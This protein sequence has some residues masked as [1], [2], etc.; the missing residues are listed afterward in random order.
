MIHHNRHLYQSVQDK[1]V[2][3]LPVSLGGFGTDNLK[4]AADVL[5]ALRYRDLNRPGGAAVLGENGEFPT[6]LLP[7]GYLP[8][9]FVALYGPATINKL[10]TATFKITNYDKDTAYNITAVNGKA[11]QYGDL[12]AFA[13]GTATGAASLTINGTTYVV[14]VTSSSPNKPSIISPLMDS[15]NNESSITFLSNTF[16][17]PSY[18][19]VHASSD[20]QLSTDADFVNIVQESLGSTTNTTSWTVSGLSPSTQYFAR[21]RHTSL[22]T[23]SSQWSNSLRLMTRAFVPM[24]AT[25]ITSPSAGALNVDTR[26]TVT[27][28][29]YQNLGGVDI[30]LSTDWEIATDVLFNNLAWS[31]LNNTTSKTSIKVT[32]LDYGVTYYIRARHK[33]STQGNGPW[34]NV[35]TFTTLAAPVISAPAITTP[36]TN[37]AE[38]VIGTALMASAFTVSAGYAN[39]TGSVWEVATDAAF[40]NIVSSSPLAAI[41]S[42]T[43]SGLTDGVTYYTRVRYEGTPT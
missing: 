40:T 26:P 8:D 31:S 19:D 6:H 36:A 21:V 39:H 18:T 4:D 33:S 34:S 5:D 14:Q 42:W 10:G 38:H 9:T 13:V 1:S 7:T 20:W 17:S 11:Y 25:S 22:T 30:H 23:G 16:S 28:S 37:G 29:A 3:L 32:G 12:I 43:P 41:T 15:S 2:N 24:Q 35:V 27:T